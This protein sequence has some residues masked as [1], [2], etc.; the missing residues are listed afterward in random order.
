M[1]RLR[2]R[3]L[4]W[5]TLPVALIGAA[6]FVKWNGLFGQF[7][8][9]LKSGPSRL[10]TGNVKPVAL[11]PREIGEGINWAGE[12][13]V[14]QA[15]QLP[16]GLSASAKNF[17]FMNDT[18]KVEVVYQSN[19]KWFTAPS[20]GA[21]KHR[22][23]GG[24]GDERRYDAFHLQRT[25]RFDLNLDGLEKA[26]QIRLR[27][28]WIVMNAYSKEV[29]AGIALAPGWD[30]RPINCRYDMTA[31]FDIEIK[32]PNSPFPQ[33]TAKNIKR[34]EVLDGALIRT[35]WG[36]EQSV[37]LRLRPLF[38]FNK[39]DEVR[40]RVG[41]P[42]LRDAKGKEIDWQ[43]KLP[44]GGYGIPFQGGSMRDDRISKT[45]PTSQILVAITGGGTEPKGGWAGVAMPMTLEGTLSDGE[46]WPQPF[47][48]EIPLFKDELDKFTGNPKPINNAHV[49]D[50]SRL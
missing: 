9:K 20:L 26:S 32:G 29:C 12:V 33:P 46:S 24:L 2:A 5:M 45:F 47:K 39:R 27:G 41:A 35:G 13:T 4:F 30:K 36:K 3:E 18:N 11:S 14:Y 8:E 28:E 37:Y 31:P 7:P 16:P 49:S 6:T 22:V 50:L 34:F 25:I 44:G 48:V 17:T 23:S 15:G 1:K 21:G 43:Y 19:G 40:V 10:I 42:K 38:S